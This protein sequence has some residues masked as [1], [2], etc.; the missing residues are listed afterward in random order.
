[1][2]KYRAK[3]VVIDGIRFASKAE[4]KRYGELKALEAAGQIKGLSLQPRYPIEVNGVK[5]CTY[6]ADFLYMEKARVDPQHGQL[7][8]P[9][10]E[11]TK[12]F[13][14]PM[15]RLKKKLVK[16]VYGIDIRET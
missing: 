7:W 10:T 16:A 14:T 15:Y 8:V 2:T 11:D 13:K 12:G 9:V 5:I 6:V 4:G 3:P 1:M